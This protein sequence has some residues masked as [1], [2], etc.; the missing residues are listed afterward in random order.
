MLKR[1]VF[2]GPYYGSVMGLSRRH[3]WIR[4]DLSMYM[5]MVNMHTWSPDWKRVIV[6]IVTIAIMGVACLSL[7]KSRAK[8]W[9]K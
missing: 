1:F 8:P 7:L 9:C 6:V 3:V 4:T 5:M 2:W